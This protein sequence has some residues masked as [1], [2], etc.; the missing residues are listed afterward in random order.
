MLILRKRVIMKFSVPFLATSIE[1]LPTLQQYGQ[2]AVEA[3]LFD[4]EE[5]GGD[6]WTLVWKNIEK[7]TQIYG[8]EQVSFHFPINRCNF[9]N[10]PFIRDRLIEA[11]KR[12]TD[13]DLRGIVIH[14]NQIEPD[15]WHDVDLR[16][17]K[18]QVV[19][20][21]ID[22]RAKVN[23]KTWL[24]LENMPVIECN[25]ETMDP[26]FIFPCDFEV[27]RVTDIKVVWD[28]CHFAKTLFNVA[29]VLSGKQDIRYYPNMRDVDQMDFLSIRDMIVH[30]HFSAFMGVANPEQGIK[31]EE[32]RQPFD[33][34][35]GESLYIKI[36][37]KI[38]ATSSPEEH[39]VFEIQEEDYCS[40]VEVQKTI[41][42]AKS[43]RPQK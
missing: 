19:E 38:L 37:E 40:R 22:I 33:S 34:T 41:K 23:G 32:G 14:S 28:I 31:S 16:A 12:A 11:L 5:L 20:S 35:A 3:I 36:L 10:D 15:L 9:V 17:K 13:F 1:Q 29:E 42:W 21:L 7:A 39:M 8:G 2:A 25:T 43:Q 26:L 18:E 24:G 27:L 30:W 4:R 6:L